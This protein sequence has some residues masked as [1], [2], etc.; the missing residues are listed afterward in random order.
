METLLVV[1][2]IV[3]AVAVLV[4]AGVLLAMYLITKRVSDNVNG[5]VSEAYKLT[6]PLERI[7]TNFRA[8]S[9]DF[10]EVGKNARQEM[11]RLESLL[12]ET[13]SAIR[14]EIQ[15]I[16][17]RV[18]LTVDEL[19]HTVMRPVREWSAIATG[20]SVGIRSFFNR[21]PKA[22]EAKDETIIIVEPTVSETPAIIIDPNIPQT[23]AA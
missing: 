8:A 21:R 13:Q 16:R 2:I 6:A 14:D 20:I 18:N 9:E 15:E 1:A 10:V 11:G 12:H 5:L 17:E 3:T 22:E 7:A 23:P 4:Q 19:Q